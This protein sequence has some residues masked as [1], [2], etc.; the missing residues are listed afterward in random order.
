MSAFQRIVPIKLISKEHLS[1]FPICGIAAAFAALVHS[2]IGA[3]IFAVEI[4]QK[5]SIHYRHLFPAILASTMNTPI[6]ASILTVELFGLFYSLP[7]SLASVIGFQI[8]R[9]NTLYDMVIEE[10]EEFQ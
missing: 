3:G 9:H 5:S 1:L 8:N 4:I 2:F 7:A 10:E 6:A